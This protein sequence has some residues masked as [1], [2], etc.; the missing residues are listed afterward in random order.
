MEHN[1]PSNKDKSK[2]EINSEG[3]E[4]IDTPNPFAHLNDDAFEESQD[5]NVDIDMDIK[6]LLKQAKTLTKIV[7]NLEPKHSE[8][9]SVKKKIFFDEEM[10]ESKSKDSAVPMIEGDA[11]SSIHQVPIPEAIVLMANIIDDQAKV[12]V[13]QALQLDFE[14]REDMA[15][16]QMDFQP[17]SIQQLPEFSATMEQRLSQPADPHSEKG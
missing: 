9:S 16:A 5:P 15:T 11:R 7:K 3:K 14:S 1:T 4:K 6:I 13:K 8:T 10:T 12:L 17:P 2:E